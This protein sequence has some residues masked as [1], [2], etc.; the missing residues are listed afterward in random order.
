[1]WCVEYA[2]PWHTIG[3]AP[4][5]G[6]V[7][8][9]DLSRARRCNPPERS[10]LVDAH[11]LRTTEKFIRMSVDLVPLPVTGSVEHSALFS[12]KNTLHAVLQNNTSAPLDG[13]MLL[14]GTYSRGNVAF[15]KKIPVSIPAEKSIDL[16]IQVTFPEPG[17]VN[18]SGSVAL[19]KQTIFI[20]SVSAA[21][22]PPFDINDPHPLVF[23]GE[24]WGVYLRIFTCGKRDMV[25]TVLKDEKIVAQRTITAIQGKSFIDLP[26]ENLAPDEYTLRIA[27]GKDAITVPL[28]IVPRI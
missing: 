22:Q 16:P 2:I 13:T 7:F 15:E 9:I 17:A 28:R 6:R 19:K 11:S 21:V 12:G 26:T 1:M 18:I 5:K 4:G 24:K 14:S 23:Q 10:V 25:L 27:S 20:S 8:G 3:I